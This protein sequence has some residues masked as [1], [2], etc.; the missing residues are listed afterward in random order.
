MFKTFN[1]VLLLDLAIEW[2]EGSN[3][4]ETKILPNGLSLL[5]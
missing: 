2:L 5:R 3:K 4:S 1:V